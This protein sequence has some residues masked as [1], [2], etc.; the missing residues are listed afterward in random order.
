M[1]SSLAADAVQQA[2]YQAAARAT[3]A[4]SIHNTQPWRFVVRPARLDV[5]ADPRRRAPVVDP[6]GRQLTISCGAALFG[7]RAALAAAQL[8]TLTTLL[9]DPGEP[10]LLAAITVGAGAD[11]AGADAD[12]RRLDAAAE[13]RHSNRRQFGADPVPDDLVDTLTRAAEAEGAWLHPVRDLPDRVAVAMLSQRADALQN[14]DQGY[15][16]ELRA[17][18]TD[19]PD[20]RDGV[21]AAA[22]PH[23]TGAAHD[24]IPIRDFDTHGDGALP[25]DT[26]SRLTQTLLVLGT[27]GDGRRDWLAAGQALGRVLLELTSAGFVASILSQVAEE[28]STRQQ[29]RQELRLT[30]QLH[31]LLRVG[32]AEPTA[33][34]PRRPLT[35]VIT[36]DPS[37]V[38]GGQPGRQPDLAPR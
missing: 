18:T 26:R 33:P 22:V 14:A 28:P 1:P 29:L 6:V 8:A 31:L 25:A 4:P 11:A 15:R 24:D 34:T 2:L 30:G 10:D 32:V 5:C 36:T 19:D 23:T 20:R 9:P 3:L 12:A 35:D 17:W 21:P 16:A 37:P 13:A 7:V 38:P 27:G